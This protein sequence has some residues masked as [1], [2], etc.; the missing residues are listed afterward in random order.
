MYYRPVVFIAKDEKVYLLTPWDQKELQLPTT[1]EGG[2]KDW[3]LTPQ[4]N[5]EAC[6]YDY[7]LASVSGKAGVKQRFV[8]NVMGSRKAKP[9][10]DPD[11]LAL[12]LSC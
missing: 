7:V 6:E 3:A 4:Y 10:S 8:H 1:G 12:A 9:I 2:C 5:N 11:R